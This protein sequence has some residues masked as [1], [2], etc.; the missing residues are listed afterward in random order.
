MG[1]SILSANS[2]SL[3]P[4]PGN[5]LSALLNRPKS[6]TETGTSTPAAEA[7]P[8]ESAGRAD[9]VEQLFNKLTY[10]AKV[11]Q[12]S[13]SL[14]AKSV[15][16]SEAGK[17]GAAVDAAQLLF[18]FY[19][20]SRTEELTL[21]QQRTAETAG[22]LPGA[23]R[24]SYLE[25]SRRIGIRFSVSLEISGA[26]LNGFSKTSDDLAVSAEDVFKEFLSFAQKAL[27]NSDEMFNMVFEL[28]DGF[29]SKGS[30]AADLFDSFMNQASLGNIFGS[31]T[32]TN[33]QVQASA[34]SFQLQL[35]F[36]FTFEQ[37][38]V[39]VEQEV[40]Q[41]DPITLDLNGNGIQLTSYR[42]G[43]RFDITGTGKAVSTAFVTGGDA[44]L[45]IDRNNNGTIDD[46]TELFGDQNGSRNGFEE[47][48][49]LDSNGDGRV[50]AAD[51]DFSKLLLWKDNGNGITEP[52][53]L[54]SLTD[55][56]IT[57]IDLG[58]RNV[59]EAAANGNRIT[60][61][62]TFLRKDGTRGTAAD[63]VLNYLA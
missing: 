60:Q 41:S 34:Q 48:R 58:Y 12:L 16:A 20:E 46:G 62:A 45:A 5:V 15:A 38:A 42:D 25:M 26:A 27:D 33:T 43:A 56:G 6:S 49:K 23:T 35:E 18:Q 47:L 32:D 61:L 40:K 10:S 7:L 51:R 24:E 1:S 36:N 11:D 22:K 37:T 57:E 50:T 63:V 2:R 55:E 28:L 3:F 29:F 8:S 19:A 52:G 9:V 17:D 4:L 31:G 14:S 53:E 30:S 21:F 44:F 59:N 13:L 54:V 39:A